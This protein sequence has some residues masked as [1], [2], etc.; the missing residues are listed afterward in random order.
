V[1]ANRRARP[2]DL[3]HLDAKTLGRI[4]GIGHRITG[5]RTHP[6]RGRV[7]AVAGMSIKGVLV[8]YSP[9]ETLQISTRCC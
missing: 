8:E 6:R 9:G 4:D 5:R 7:G 2:G 3:L 1:V